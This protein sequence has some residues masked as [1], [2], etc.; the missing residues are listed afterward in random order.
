MRGEA[1]AAKRSARAGAGREGQNSR[2]FAQS[3]QKNFKKI[4]EKFWRTGK[5][6]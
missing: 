6:A 2:N 5:K 3:P 4:A 1:R